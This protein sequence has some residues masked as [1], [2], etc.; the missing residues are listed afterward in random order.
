MTDPR[1][2]DPSG[3][4]RS[5]A[6]TLA[7]ALEAYLADLEAGRPTD[8]GEL[9]ARHPDLETQL[10]EC[11]QAIDFV[12]DARRKLEGLPGASAVLG[13]FRILREVGSGGMGV[14]YEAEQ[15][16]LKRRVALKVL[17]FGQTGDPE[18]MRRFHREAEIVGR[19]HHTNIVP[20]YA[21]G[22][23]DGVQYFAM[24]F[25]D[26][27]SLAE[28]GGEDSEPVAL[29]DVLQFGIE[30]AEALAHAHE[31]GVIHRDVK[32]SNLLLDGDGRVWLTDFGLARQHDDLTLSLTGALLGTPR[33]MSPE[34]A[35]SDGPPVDH[36]ADVY[37][38]GATLYELATGQPVFVAK[39]P[40][41]VLRCIVDDEPMSP[42]R[43]DG[44]L[45][46][47]FETIVM[48]CLE[49][50][51]ERR[52][53]TAAD[54]ARDLRA[55]R[56]GDAISAR[57]PNVIE[58][59][60]RS[61]KR[62]RRSAA[63][64]LA[65]A[66]IALAAL[67]VGVLGM[68]EYADTQN[69][70][71]EVTAKTAGALVSIFDADGREAVAPFR[72]P[73]SEPI[74]L[75]AGRYRIR[76]IESDLLSEEFAVDVDAGVT[77]ECEL[78][79]RDRLMW[80]PIEAERDGRL[81]YAFL[82]TEAGTDLLV[83][84]EQALARVDGRTRETL[85]RW[86]WPN[87]RVS[88]ATAALGLDDAAIRTVYSNWRVPDV[89]DDLDGDGVSDFVV[90]K[91]G[92]RAFVAS[93]ASGKLLWRLGA[94]GE[95][96]AGSIVTGGRLHVL[97]SAGSAARLTAFDGKTGE[98]AWE[99]PLEVD[100]EDAEIQRGRI[101]E[102]DVLV[103]AIGRHL[104]VCD[105]T[106]G[107]RIG[108]PIVARG[109]FSGT[110]RIEDLDGDGGDDV[111]VTIARDQGALMTAYALIDG[112][113]LWSRALTAEWG[114]RDGRIPDWPVVAPLDD[115]V[116]VLAPTRIA[117]AIE[118]GYAVEA[119]DGTSGEPRWRRFWF[120]DAARQ[121][122]EVSP[123]D[124]VAQAVTEGLAQEAGPLGALLG[125]AFGADAP[126]RV[127]IDHL[128]VGP[129]IDRDGLGDV[130]TA[131]VQ[132]RWLYVTA[133]SSAS[134]ET[135]WWWSTYA[136]GGGDVGS[137]D[138]GMA[139]P[140]GE[141]LVIVAYDNEQGR[142]R[143]VTR[144]GV[145]LHQTPSRVFA[146]EATRGRVV[147]ELEGVPELR[148]ADLDA[149]GSTELLALR[150]RSSSELARFESE[151]SLRAFR[152]MGGMRYR[153]LEALHRAADFNS[154]GVTDLVGKDV[155][156]S[157]LDGRVLW[158]VD[159]FAARHVV[160]APLGDLDEDGVADPIDADGPGAKAFSGKT[161][162]LL[163]EL[164]TDA[165]HP[166][167]GAPMKGISRG[168][169]MADAR[170]VDLDRDGDLELV[171]PYG[172][173]TSFLGGESPRIAVVDAT[174]GQV[175]FDVASGS[176]RSNNDRFELVFGD[177]DG[178]AVDDIITCSLNAASRWELRAFRG[179]DGSVLFEEGL[180]E[181]NYGGRRCP[182]ACV[183]ADL[184]AD[185]F[186][187]AIV[188]DRVLRLREPFAPE[189]GH[190]RNIIVESAQFRVRALRG[191]DGQ[192]IWT[193]QSEDDGEHSIP[194]GHESWLARIDAARIA[195]GGRCVCVQL[196]TE[197]H[198][199][200]K[201]G[202]LNKRSH[203][204]SLRALVL[205]GEGRVVHASAPR[206]VGRYIA[207]L[208]GGNSCAVRAVDVDGDGFE[209]VLWSAPGELVCSRGRPDDVLWKAEVSGKP[210]TFDPVEP[211]GRMR[212]TATGSWLELPRHEQRGRVV[213]V[214]DVAN[215]ATASSVTG[216]EL[217][218]LD[219]A[220]RPL[221]VARTK[222]GSSGWLGSPLAGASR[223]RPVLAQ[224]PPDPRYLRRLP[225]VRPGQVFVMLRHAADAALLLV[226]PLLLLA[227]A[228]R[229]R[230]W[231]VGAVLLGY[232]GVAL[233]AWQLGFV[234]FT[235]IISTWETFARTIDLY[236]LFPFL[237]KLSIG[238]V[239]IGI[240]LAGAPLV[241]APMCA[242][243]WLGR[244]RWGRFAL[245]V[246]VW[247]AIAVAFGAYYLAADASFM[248]ELEHY[249]WH[250][251]EAIG[252]EAAFVVGCLLVLL[253]AG[254]SLLRLG[255][256]RRV[257]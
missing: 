228:I 41:E 223:E 82:A 235:R 203:Q 27:T 65:S 234:P 239:S 83:R 141:P 96:R 210:V 247:S 12:H 98:R 142:G 236:A 124:L 34:Q 81:R 250:G 155:A 209:E 56:D 85:W 212:R 131:C 116:L 171:Y 8:R 4:S 120:D 94:G 134:G 91:Q 100:G 50:D 122:R 232:M 5:S 45:P 195:G 72:M 17:R 237:Q 199:E 137:L 253:W 117:D 157:G 211:I 194:D 108:G 196:V 255:S 21:V 52:Y 215:G 184:D 185:G 13:D 123:G 78:R 10:D 128:G 46:R 68:R 119:I 201:G 219:V 204:E 11:L 190:S 177:L 115:G 213:H 58:R 156:V 74:S 48:K 208:D 140:D 62:H 222:G 109:D 206:A 127:Q 182:I 77:R 225:W 205:D 216:D 129:D 54:L 162:Q 125:A 35:R 73:A 248:S 76:A 256:Q 139:G 107:R 138:F 29:P 59:A 149:D 121:M 186:G 233:A 113:V 20:V 145:Q 251:G 170:L 114:E 9:L 174:S 166:V 7:T 103:T 18:A 226:L 44:A 63:I 176:A 240:V 53:A 55:L 173:R 153:R 87:W 86:E 181:R 32:P 227:W 42:R 88:A 130:F 241:I 147:H 245:L 111:L 69:G 143:V 243:V 221:A 218:S 189:R 104:V 118:S 14:V 31:R 51:P 257:A 24:Q 28:L 231:G 106:D 135:L 89:V 246:L 57:R 254:R 191:T 202:P 164:G 197:G 49:K 37:S 188:V 60:G 110:P 39:T 198:Y 1:P 178:D 26:G 133:M 252:L 97:S 75:P 158:R 144:D 136:S 132:E 244:R 148:L 33:Y 230:S 66:V 90:G 179:A 80:A 47:D 160:P 224:V 105:S 192:P 169:S 220:G 67:A 146:L 238:D 43:V 151:A 3:G 167:E 207:N 99:L 161:G 30:A 168:S 172:S 150:R 61:W 23:T 93:G 40:H 38:L 159:D 249:S 112:Q 152:G 187:E 64:A 229:W 71:L 22:E 15:M 70:R 154:D 79:L 84:S 95:L 36:R 163:W 183:V 2:Q 102:R 165:L 6:E 19:L 16:S 180:S 200:R 92:A 214:I 242:L 175:E 217:L 25:I 101:A 126:D 193:W